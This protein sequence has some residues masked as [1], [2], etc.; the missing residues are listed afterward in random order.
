[1]IA[2]LV[3]NTTDRA[4]VLAHMSKHNKEIEHRFGAAA[5][6]QGAGITPES[7][8]VL[9]SFLSHLLSRGI[10]SDLQAQAADCEV[11]QGL[12]RAG[13]GERQSTCTSRCHVAGVAVAT[14]FM[15]VLQLMHGDAKQLAQHI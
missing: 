12:P 1:V 8:P 14:L 9:R 2:E 11:L 5:A 13:T 10:I 3:F 4:E 6:A 7:L 15:R